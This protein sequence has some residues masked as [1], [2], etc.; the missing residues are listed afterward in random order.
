[1]LISY[2]A[3]FA[4][5]W[6]RKAR[7]IIDEHGP[8]VFGIRVRE[9]VAARDNW[10]VEKT[11]NGGIT[12]EKTGGSMITAG[13]GGPITGRGADLAIVDDPIKN[14]EEAF[15]PTVRE[16]TW[17]WFQ[18]TFMS[19]LEPGA[20][21]IV[22]QTRWHEDDLAG[23][24]IE[25]SNQGGEHWNVINFPALAYEESGTLGYER[26][27]LGRK[28]GEALWP[29][30]YDEKAL[31]KIRVERGE[32]WF[33][34]L[35]QQK[36]IPTGK[37]IFNRADKRNYT[38]TGVAMDGSNYIYQLQT[39]S[40]PEIVSGF[41]LFKFATV[42][43]AVSTKQTADFTVVSTWGLTPT[44]DLILLDVQR[45]RLEGPDQ[46]PLLTSV[47]LSQHPT[48]FYIE[49]TA[50]QLSLIQTALRAG[51]PVFPVTPDKDKIARALP[52]AAKMKAGK[53]YFPLVADWLPEVEKE[54]FNFPAAKHDDFVDTLSMAVNVAIGDGYVGNLR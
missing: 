46:T 12:W 15:S 22:I 51:L 3:E 25:A 20:R 43:L 29:E 39:P 36:P 31:N 38:T 17:E 54:L 50:Y 24:L 41:E 27:I 37:S 2:A 33:S 30:R 7:D 26:D 32:Y 16:K 44:S 1:M 13:V 52:A 45:I 34:A 53:I 47:W 10:E 6:G 35:Y 28:P 11:F 49:A 8:A 9:D 21:V 18:S 42:D 4:A 40:G 48:A 19:R 23:R 14:A 5:F